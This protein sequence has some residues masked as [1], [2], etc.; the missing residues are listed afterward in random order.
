MKHLSISL[1]PAAFVL[2]VAGCDSPPEP[3]APSNP[4]PPATTAP[5]VASSSAPPAATAPA[6]QPPVDD[7]TAIGRIVC[8]GDPTTTKVGEATVPACKS[9]P[10]DSDYAQMTNVPISI[11]YGKFSGATDEAIA[12]LHGCGKGRPGGEVILLRHAP[13]GWEKVYAEGG[14][15]GEVC[16]VYPAQPA[17][18]VCDGGGTGTGTVATA[19]QVL[20]AGAKNFDPSTVVGLT[21]DAGGT[22]EKGK[23]HIEARVLGWELK[24]L[25]GDK[26]DDLLVRAKGSKG[27]VTKAGPCKDVK[28]PTPV[29][30]ELKFVFDGTT[31]KPDPAAEKVIKSLS[32]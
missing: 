19:V 5:A 26:K 17:F 11:F 9:C 8:G 16:K 12:A 18:L 28:V 29:T 23:T 27:V 6:P 4:P 30:H 7:A 3:A 13:T 2:A 31:F 24:D 25:N 15:L 20:R 32:P 10:A 14:M 1:V 21:A 22:C